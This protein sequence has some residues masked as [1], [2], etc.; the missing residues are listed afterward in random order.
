MLKKT[1]AEYVN[2]AEDTTV[3]YYFFKLVEDLYW[4]TS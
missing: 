3:L 2:S 4:H 1:L